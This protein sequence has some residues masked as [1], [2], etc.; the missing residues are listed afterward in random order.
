M[1]TIKVTCY[2]I[3][4]TICHSYIAVNDD[5]YQDTI[6]ALREDIPK[7]LRHPQTNEYSIYRFGDLFVTCDNLVACKID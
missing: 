3:G 7:I 2:F 4:N 1:K 6:E 5:E